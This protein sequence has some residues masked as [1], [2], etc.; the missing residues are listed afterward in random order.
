MNPSPPVLV[1]ALSHNDAAL[2]PLADTPAAVLRIEISGSIVT[3][4]LS[5]NSSRDRLLRRSDEYPITAMSWSPLSELLASVL[6]YLYKMGR[7]SS[8]AGRPLG[9]VFDSLARRVVRAVEVRRG[10]ASSGLVAWAKSGRK[11]A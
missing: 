7:A 4:L 2:S 6:R 5:Q 1:V 10:M 8:L 9:F 11:G 3:S